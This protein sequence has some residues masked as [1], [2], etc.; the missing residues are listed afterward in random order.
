MLKQELADQLIH[1]EVDA[2]LARAP[3][4][5]VTVVGSGMAGTPGVA[6]RLFSS[7]GAARI[8]VMAIAQGSTEYSISFVV[9]D[10][11]AAEAVAVAHRE[12]VED[13]E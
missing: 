1:H 6:G 13:G 9:E 3:V 2:V 12:F 4:A 7:M 11:L 10:A 8:N 5:I